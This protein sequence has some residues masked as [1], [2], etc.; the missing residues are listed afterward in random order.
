MDRFSLEPIGEVAQR[1]SLDSL[2]PG[3]HVIT[4]ECQ[5]DT[6][7]SAGR[8]RIRDNLVLPHHRL[9]RLLGVLQTG[10]GRLAVMLDGGNLAVLRRDL[11]DLLDER[12]GGTGRCGVSANV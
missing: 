4:L 2:R 11:Q 12:V 3:D 7:A 10:A 9:D 5:D 6:G 1:F 8:A